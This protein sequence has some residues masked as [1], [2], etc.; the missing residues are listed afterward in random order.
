MS[1]GVG[2]TTTLGEAAAAAGAPGT[3]GWGLWVVLALVVGVGLG[4]LTALLSTRGRR[5]RGQ[6]SVAVAAP[7]PPRATGAV[8]PVAEP[9]VDD[10]HA[11][12]HAPPG[13]TAEAPRAATPTVV[14]PPVAARPA[15]G[16]TSSDRAPQPAAGGARAWRSRRTVATA[17]AVGAVLLV[18]GA[19]TVD[20]AGAR[21]A[22]DG[23]GPEDVRAG[24]G[25]G[26]T[27]TP[28]ARTLV[29][30]PPTAAGPPAA[31]DLA[32]DTVALGRRGA[33]ASLLFS[34]IV[35]EPRAVGL[36]VSYPSVNLTT[37]GERSVAHVA[38]PTWNCL[39]TAPPVDPVAAGCLPTPTEY[40][41]LSA[42]DLTVTG[43][44][45]T[46]RLTGLFPTYTRPNGSAP[47][48]TGRSYR[49]TVDVEPAGRVR[50]GRVGASGRLLLGDGVATT[51]GGPLVDV[52]LVND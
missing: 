31:G 34:G 7:A 16:S 33:G 37:D 45:G 25:V 36:T 49:L 12:F 46:L 39:T 2:S 1:A 43:E 40:A 42:P 47:A 51:T 6:P 27:A 52:L 29:P 4:V 41:D 9:E 35:L 24:A 14:A 28:P 13:S 22:P 44:D 32:D 26:T 17:T 20:R 48:Y 10:L 15:S 11:F 23:G 3:S 5:G 50:D 21:Q 18:A 38:L 30:A 19:V 8:P